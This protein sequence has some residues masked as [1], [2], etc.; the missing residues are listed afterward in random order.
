M[1]SSWPPRSIVSNY[2]LASACRCSCTERMAM[3]PSPTAEATLLTEPYRTSPA[4]KTPN[5][6]VSRSSGR[7]AD[8]LPLGRSRPV[9]MKPYRA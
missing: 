8:D 7:V 5:M 9:K 3:E 1:T 6:L 4:A 2:C